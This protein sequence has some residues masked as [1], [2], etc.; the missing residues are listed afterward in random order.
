MML[1]CRL[2]GGAALGGGPRFCD[3]RQLSLFFGTGCGGT[4]EF[5][6]GKLA[7]TC[8]R[9]GTLLR[10]NPALQ[11]R[12]S[13]AFGIRPV[14]VDLGFSSA[15][16]RLGG[17]RLTL[18]FDSRGSG[19]RDLRFLLGAL[20]G[21]LQ[22]PLFG[23]GTRPGSDFS[24]P[25]GMMLH[26]RL[27]G[28][29]TLGGGPRFCNARQL[30]LFFNPRLG[31]ACEF[32][33][34]AFAT[35]RLGQGALFRFNSTLQR[36]FGLTLGTCLQGNRR[37]GLAVGGSAA[38]RPV[39]RQR[40]RLLTPLRCICQ[41]RRLH[42]ARLGDN[43]GA[44]VCRSPIQGIAFGL[45]LA[46]GR[47]RCGSS[48]SCSERP[49]FALRFHQSCQQFAQAHAPGSGPW[50]TVRVRQANPD[51]SWAEGRIGRWKYVKPC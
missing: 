10:F 16:C 47:V 2:L 45:V 1:C 28:G 43:P 5:G 41:L 31:S 18:G 21:F 3:A 48:R 37:F 14:G 42:L 24:L 6:G 36:R 30:G 15:A 34:G 19:A 7:T 38:Q 39:C 17:R 11:R 27:L 22:R 50:L 12:G 33:G 49:T 46:A 40:F 20:S 51:R 35:P 44:L 29:A 9:Q 25:L 32:G 23:G 8:L 26:C 4:G 13:S